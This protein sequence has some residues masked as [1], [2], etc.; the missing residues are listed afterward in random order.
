MTNPNLT[1]LALIC[2]RSGSMHSIAG[3]MN[4]AIHTL[5]EDQ[6]KGVGDIKVD[7][8]TFDTKI[9]HPYADANPGDIKEDLILPR[10]STALNDA[11]GLAITKLG[12][13]FAALP[14]E[15]RPGKVI[16]VIVTD[17]YENASHEWTHEQIKALVEKQTSEY[18]WEFVYLA[19]NVDAFA[20]GASY[21]YVGDNSMEYVASA[22]GVANAMRSASNYI[23]NSRSGI[24]AGFS[25]ED[26]AEAMEE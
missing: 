17:G 9:D 11:T 8:W 19:A 10:G 16:V 5:L 1:H 18:G 12:E 15:E 20:T 24:V 7:V 3:D 14:E 22:A 2:D 13:R 21:G 23:T 6:A 4:G 26:R 25:D